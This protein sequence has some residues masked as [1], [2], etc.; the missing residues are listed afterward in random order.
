MTIE[1]TDTVA[2]RTLGDRVRKLRVRLGMSQVRLAG[3]GLSDSYISLIESD[4]RVPSP[5][6]IEELARRLGCS[7]GYLECGI[8]EEDLADLRLRLRSA[9][10][11]L[12][13]GRVEEALG[14]FGELVRVPHLVKLPE[15][16]RQTRVGHALALEASGDLRRAIAELEV[17]A[18]RVAA[19]DWEGWADLQIALLRCRRRGGDAQAVTAA[20]Q[21]LARL[22]AARADSTDSAIGL[23][24]TLVEVY[25]AD[26]H[27]LLA[28]Q[29]AWQLVR[30]AETSGSPRAQMDA[31]WRAAAVA[32]A[33]GESER[34]VE[35][36]ERA[37][38]FLTDDEQVRA[39][40][41]LHVFHAAL[42]LKARPDQ[43]DRARA[44]LTLHHQQPGH[45]P[46]DRAACLVELGRAEVALGFPETAL[47]SAQQAIHLVGDTV[48][49]A[50][51]HAYAVLGDAYDR[52]GKHADAIDTLTRS[53]GLLDQLGLPREAAQVW[54]RLAEL[55]E[56]HGAG[57]HQ[58][59]ETYR[60]AL[61][62]IGLLSKN[63]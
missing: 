52:L 26:G 47:E 3:P 6:V 9:H 17:L 38:A 31:Y 60:R 35:V 50:G 30:T 14:I 36:A 27:L 5:A 46:A 51:A 29:L 55:L 45:T 32:D 42:L 19:V 63:R 15:L 62:S 44:F 2:E 1:P 61:S 22:A 12:S 4:K 59:V 25:L 48:C 53:A 37:L 33:D 57:A 18:D 13:N 34:A 11:A 41:S 58:Q 7:A 10:N 16:Y 40:G 43:A 21:A 56:R 54:I 24:V 23:G 39:L 20:E 49:R 28:R 8:G